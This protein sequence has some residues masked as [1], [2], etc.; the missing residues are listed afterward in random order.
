MSEEEVDEKEEEP[1]P[2]PRW[3]PIL[4]GAVLVVLGALAVMTGLRYR[5]ETLVNI[6]R[7]HAAVPPATTPAPPGEPEAGASLILPGGNAPA[8]HPPVA[9]KARAEISGSG[10]AVES[11]VRIW[12]RRGMT[13]QIAPD[14]AIVYV[15]EVPV[16][17]AKQFSNQAYEFADAGSYTV[18]V[19]APGYRD[20]VFTVTAAENAKEEIARIEAKL[21]K[22]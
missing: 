21:T 16:G 14:D 17:Q 9:G 3:V 13:T 2:L 6:V 1:S 12:A 22:P 10:N 15:N 5:Q 8:A 7:P 19:T 11:N 20:R 4:I 18:R